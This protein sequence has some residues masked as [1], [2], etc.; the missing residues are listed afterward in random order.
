MT[1]RTALVF[2]LTIACGAAPAPGSKPVP[3]APA[4]PRGSPPVLVKPE[5]AEAHFGELRQLT[6]EG[7]NAEAY[8]SG[9]GRSLSL[10]AKLPGHD[11]DRIYRMDIASGSTERVLVSSGQG[12][13]TCAHYLPG[14]REILYASTHLAGAACPP[15]PDHS[16]GYVWPLYPSYDIFKAG[17]DGTN[18]VRLTDAPGYDAEGTACK[19]DGTILF[20]SVRDGDLD[21]YRMDRD[22]KNVVRLTSSPGYDGG[23]FF[24]ADC[25]RIVWRASRPKPGK[26]LDAYKAL[27][28]ENLVRPS[29]LEIYVANADG[30]EP[31]Q[32]T[33]LDAASFAPFF[34]PSGERILFSS[35]YGDPKGREFDLWA[36]DD[37]GARLERITHA[38]GF[39]GFPIFS[40]DGKT[41]AFS[42]NRRTQ[43]GSHDT[44]VFLAPWLEGRV[45]TTVET[46]ADRVITD[47]AYLAD[48]GREG[49]GLGQAGLAAAGEH[50]EK[51]FQALGVQPAGDGQTFRQAFS[52][53]TAIALAPASRVVV[54]DRTLDA[55][56]F[57]PLGFSPAKSDVTAPLVLAGYG[58][59]D[60]AKKRDDYQGVAARGKVVVVR[61][62]VPDSADFEKTED[63]RRFGD[64]RYK[65]WLAKERGA[66]G[67]IVV[68]DP[69]PPAP[70]VPDWKPPAEA[71][72]PSLSPEGYGDA[73]I[74]VLMVKRDVLRPALDKLAK[75]QPAKVELK[76]E[77]T[78]VQASAFNVIGKI[79][80]G[81]DEKRRLP[82]T[83]VIGAHYDHLGLG[84]RHSLAPDKHEPHVGADDN[85][86][87]VAGVLEIARSLTAR[88]AEL[89]RD[90]LVIGFSGEESGLL[91]SS[92]F[93]K[94]AEAGKVPALPPKST[95]AMLNL[96]MIGRLRENKLAVLG[97]E[98]AAEWP[99][100]LK[101]PCVLARVECSVT[102]DGGYGPSDQ[103]SFFLSGVPVL[104]F[105]TGAHADYHKPSDTTDKINA[106]GAGQIAQIVAE[107]T[108][109]VS[110]QPK[111]LRF[112]PG[113]KSQPP[114]GDLRSFNASLGTI[115]DYAGPGPG[116]SGVL[117]GGVRPGGAAERAGMRRGDLLVRL[118]RHEI[119]SIEDFMFVLNASKPGETT[120]ATVVRNGKKVELDVTF[121][122][123]AGRPK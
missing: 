4:T 17:V 78:S 57:A 5:A 105:F 80:A 50:I 88:R 18:V 11:C 28:A 102:P 39:D 74:P 24:N 3:A 69:L 53:S 120:K 63:K 29:K 123:S 71:A 83:I 58:I 61:R 13:T 42:S 100:L 19:K 33:Y 9:D 112:N 98:T 35:N 81:V 41:L 99:D 44:H 26:E 14:D 59:V 54:D 89:A 40:P 12:A 49:R 46:A 79:P 31:M 96:D 72:L 8:W 1:I 62:F 106:A 75:K 45:A 56:E 92:H 103:M 85:A 22:G 25:T 20:T 47:I 119:A 65:V 2:L 122:E 30:S 27:L 34:H 77:L 109:R 116:K 94:A 97:G 21:L 87:G 113:A 90:V 60:K 91:G 114:G 101:E 95:F 111:P 16:K 76:L 73:G 67:V 82:G 7:E 38:P 10:Q 23:A 6:F 110:Q 64:L 68:D 115:P 52:V 36:V 86:S 32:V 108:L 43:P 15:K 118:G 48:P 51:R 66:R 117:L 104:H 107:L 37:S 84:G 70:A 121:Q 93:V 55:K